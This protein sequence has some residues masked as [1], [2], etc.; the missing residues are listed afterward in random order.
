MKRMKKIV[1]WMLLFVLVFT[2]VPSFETAAK[3]ASEDDVV[4]NALDYGVD[5]TGEA[6]STVAIQNAFAAAK[7]DSIILLTQTV[8]KILQRPSVFSLKVMKI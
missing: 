2:S 8:L 4:I 7:K 5:P 6:D 1:A 3:E